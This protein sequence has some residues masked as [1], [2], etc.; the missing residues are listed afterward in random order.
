MN[1]V[2][3]IWRPALGMI[4]P[5]LRTQPVSA[6]E[7]ADT[8]QFA[9]QPI[10]HLETGVTHGVEALLRNQHTLGFETISDLF[11]AAH[12]CGALAVLEAHL[13]NRAVKDFLAADYPD[14]FRLFFNLD[15]RTINDFD[16]LQD[17][18]DH[19]LEERGLDAKRLC[20]EINEQVD[21]DLGGDTTRRLHA[22]RESGVR[23]A[24]DDFGSGYSRFKVLHDQHADYVKF[25][26][27]F[28]DNVSTR[29][30]KRVFLSS[31]LEM[32]H[33]LGVTTV[34][35]G[36]ETEAD[37]QSCHELGFCLAQGYF[38]ARPTLD[39]RTVQNCY[40]NMH[41]PEHWRSKDRKD[42]DRDH[43]QDFPG[44]AP[45]RLS[46]TAR[47][48]MHRFKTLDVSAL[49]V[50]DE[51][52][53]PVGIVLA[54]DLWRAASSKGDAPFEDVDLTGF[55]RSCPIAT[56]GLPTEAY[57]QTCGDADE[58]HGVLLIDDNRFAG[59]LDPGS[60]LRA[61]SDEN[62]A[63]VRDRNVLTKLPGDS[64]IRDFVSAATSELD[65]DWM[66]IRF[67]FDDFSTFNDAY[68]ISHAD[69]A[70]VMFSDRLKRWYLGDSVMLGHRGGDE[71]WVILKSPDVASVTTATYGLRRA[72]AFDSAGFEQEIPEKRRS[73][74]STK[75]ALPNVNTPP[76][77]CRAAILLL[78]RGRDEL[79]YA[80][81]TR[82]LDELDRRAKNEGGFAFDSFG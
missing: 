66:V 32:F 62:I 18:I 75:T 78:K 4:T 55:L 64:Y 82:M 70:I 15:P 35:E 30:E 68:G 73:R 61:L 63:S 21:L 41:K 67:N 46:S 58:A 33:L 16:Q 45:L 6:R 43:V 11:D 20:L 34:A 52:D 77:T 49:P 7:V 14:G 71:F 40:D 74:V 9:F 24:L 5:R 44:P 22:L 12:L 10:M 81:I 27:Y 42:D 69:R 28:V 17:M 1:L 8:V 79:N 38:I 3:S 25:D 29:P 80:Q 31:M 65:T 50:T 57:L 39:H 54:A 47:E 36:I 56:S 26:R 72:F 23:V 59:F 53:R 76:L 48:A 19:T 2:S 13:L 60:I 37:L 51:I